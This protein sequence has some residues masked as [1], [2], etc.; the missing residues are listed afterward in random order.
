MSRSKVSRILRAVAINALLV[1]LLIPVMSLA[2]VEWAAYRATLERQSRFPITNTVAWLAD[3]GPGYNPENMYWVV[4]YDCRETDVAIQGI[5]PPAKYWS[6]VP[7]DRYTMPLSSYLTDEMV[8]KEYTGRYVAYLTARPQGRTNEINVSAS[9]RGLLLIRI[10]LPDD[11]QEVA[12]QAPIVRPV[13][14]D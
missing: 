4:E 6:M 11:P 5:V 1:A 14:R 10:L 12:R 8:Q 7:Y 2:A 9:P 13:A 3:D